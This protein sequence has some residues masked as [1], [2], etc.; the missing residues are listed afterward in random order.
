MYMFPELKS[1]GGVQGTDPDSQSPSELSSGTSP[2]DS[3]VAEVT[4]VTVQK[5]PFPQSRSILR[6]LLRSD[7]SRKAQLSKDA[8]H[9]TFNNVELHWKRFTVANAKV[10]GRSG[11]YRI[12]METPTIDPQALA[13]LPRA[14]KPVS[15]KDA[16]QDLSSAVSQDYK[17]AFIPSPELVGAWVEGIN[18]NL[19]EADEPLISVEDAQNDLA[20]ATE[21]ARQLRKVIANFAKRKS[22]SVERYRI[23]LGGKL[24]PSVEGLIEDHLMLPPRNAVVF[25]DMF[26]KLLY[27]QTKEGPIFYGRWGSLII[28]DASELVLVLAKRRSRKLAKVLKG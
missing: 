25:L 26:N 10:R 18:E 8:S 16:S 14:T 11:A 15:F 19:R 23:T 12:K 13:L 24:Y 28:D 20:Y 27:D 6:Q 9:I 5:I 3:F 22:Y 17:R 7:F 2:S 4:E 1:T 21:L